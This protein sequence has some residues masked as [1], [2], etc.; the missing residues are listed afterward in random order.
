MSVAAPDWGEDS[1]FYLPNE[2]V[3]V[4]R[5]V[6]R[7]FRSRVQRPVF[8]GG[9]GMALLES[10]AILSKVETVTF[11]DL[12][13]FQLDYFERLQCAL[14]QSASPGELQ[15]W[16]VKQ[17]IP[18][19]R[20]HFRRRGLEFTPGQV[21]LALKR[22]FNVG[23]FFD[24]RPFDGVRKLLPYIITKCDDI[25]SYLARCGTHHDFIYL[26]NVPDYLP[27]PALNAL[28]S[29]CGRHA[30]PVY[31]LLTT[32]CADRDSVIAVFDAAGFR[33][34]PVNEQL[35]ARNR[36]LGSPTLNKTWNRPGRIHLYVPKTS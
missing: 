18:E 32:A 11:V 13:V 1:R 9:S 36:G 21:L 31:L 8:V 15:N 5:T 35:N 20:E 19:L 33:E 26:S 29:A 10:S 28:A 3:S 17:I 34:H 12:A 22:R 4:L 23:F 2:D 16:F 14:R 6:M 7:L 27:P 25:V 30:A 24:E